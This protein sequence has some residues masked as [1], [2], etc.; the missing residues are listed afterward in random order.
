MR[1]RRKSHF[2]VVSGVSALTAVLAFTLVQSSSSV[3]AATTAAPTS[4]APPTISGV[5]R[6]GQTLT[7]SPGTWTGT[8][9][10]SFVYRWQRCD[11]NGG[12]CVFSSGTT[13]QTTGLLTSADVGS[14]IRVVVTASNA[15][16]SATETSVPTAVVTA[17]ATGPVNTAP[18][19]ISGT[20]Q[21]GRTLTIAP[22]TWTGTTPITFVY[23]WQRC[24]S[25][26]GS[27]VPSGGTTTQTTA[28]LTG[29]DV[30]STLRVVVT[31]TNAG[32]SSSAT[33]APTAVV[34]AAPA[35]GGCAKTGGTVPVS[36]VTAPARLIVDRAEVVD[37]ARLTHASRSL[38]LRVHVGACGG[39]VEGALVYAT[40]VPY[41][42]FS[43]PREQATGPDGWVT[44]YLPALAGYPVSSKQQLLVTFVRARKPGEDI[45]AGISNR[46]LVSF[47]V[48]RS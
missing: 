41:G 47:R 6:A 35:A 8:P 17:A 12:N 21:A 30:G 33:S 15:D 3:D 23:Q 18:P 31:A 25:S 48:T 19:T 26:G 43:I 4:T 28:V 44:L 38:T 27:C 36:G 34:T 7:A 16:G 29:A 14:T 22:G 11:A 10:I 40:A 39:S 5:A 46:R 2:L 42:Q 9:P 13:T 24:N 32:G 1:L 37:P 20:P 45:L